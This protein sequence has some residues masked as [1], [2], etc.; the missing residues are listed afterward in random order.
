[1]RRRKAF[2]LTKKER[3]LAAVNLLRE[4]YPNAICSL[5]YEFPFQLLVA[6]RLSAQCTDARVNLVTPAL[7]ER[8]KTIEDFANADPAEVGKYIYS[9][10]F[11]KSKAESIVGMA[12]KILADYNGEVPD[13]ID[14][15]LTLPGV[16][17]K[18]ANLIVG[19]I[20]GKAAHC[21][22][23]ALHTHHKQARPCGGKRPEKNR[24]CAQKNN[25]CAGRLG[26][27]PQN[28]SFRQRGLHGK[29]SKVR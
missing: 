20:Y 13:N 23:Y 21:G 26:F 9:C 1:M 17:R 18:T 6:V 24:I 28:C 3:A 11:Y 19:D 14:D 27:L 25:S 4:M 7:F 8:Y 12:Q 10:G 2:K 15:L 16:G 5:D 22:G 29:K